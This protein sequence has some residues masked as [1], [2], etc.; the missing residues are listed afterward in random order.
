MKISSGQWK[1][2]ERGS[3]KGRCHVFK[4]RT[5]V[6]KATCQGE[7]DK[8]GK[9]GSKSEPQIKQGRGEIKQGRSDISD[10]LLKCTSVL[11]MSRA[12]SVFSPAKL[13]RTTPGEFGNR[14]FCN[15]HAFCHVKDSSSDLR[16]S[17]IRFS[18]TKKHQT[19]SKSA[20][21][22]EPK[23]FFSPLYVHTSQENAFHAFK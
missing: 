23:A 4:A 10:A 3:A 6:E 5:A 21:T 20:Q 1:F 19:E 17:D 15:L 16:N 13:K 9:Q 22:G 14:S 11:G 7:K 8:S 18:L 12:K 2:Q